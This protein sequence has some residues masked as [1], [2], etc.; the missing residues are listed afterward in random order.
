[1]RQNMSKLLILYYF[2][3]SLFLFI[4]IWCITHTFQQIN[5]FNIDTHG[6]MQ[7]QL[8]LWG[9]T[10][11]HHEEML[12][13]WLYL[14]PS[15]GVMEGNGMKCWGWCWGGQCGAK[16]VMKSSSEVLPEFQ[17]WVLLMDNSDCLPT[18][19][20]PL[21]QVAAAV[22][23]GWGILSTGLSSLCRSGLPGW[24]VG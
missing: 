1:M 10:E 8:Q 3:Y 6:T 22:E 12:H 13:W 24:R 4:Y 20:W 2:I 5:Q 15:V 23:G 18:Q 9:S 11:E 21:W 14:G 7:S 17:R 16:A 19:H